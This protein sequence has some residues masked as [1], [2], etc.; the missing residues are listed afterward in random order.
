MFKVFNI[1]KNYRLKSYNI[2]LYALVIIAAIYGLIM[3][4][5]ADNSFTLKQAFG[6]VLA[7][8]WMTFLS[9][10][11]FNKLLKWHKLWYILAIILLIAVL[12]IGTKV[13]GATRWIVIGGFRIQPSEITKILLIL[14]FSKVII[15]QREKMDSWRFLGILTILLFIPLFL[16][17]N[18]PDLSQ[19]IL[20]FLILFVVIF[21]GGL[22]YKKLGKILAILVPILIVAFIYITNPNQKL[23]KPYQWVRVMA[24]INPEKYDDSIYQQQNSVVAIGSGGLTGK[25][26]NNEDP[27]SLLNNNYIPE[28]HTDFIFAAVG[29]QLGFIG[30]LSIVALLLFIIFEI[31]AVALKTKSEKGRLIAIGVATHIALQTFLNIGVVTRLLPN[32]GLALPFF[33]YGLSSLMTLATGIGIVLNISLQIEPYKHKDIYT[34][35]FVDIKFYRKKDR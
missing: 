15:K 25:G 2:R 19:T 18:E 35:D 21:V 24:F 27:T 5:S 14:F 17:V 12:V 32:T 34:K 11:D 30:V 4:N 29:E 22:S 33:S 31:I 26:L 13:L 16:I 7:I 6:I 8:S 20:T 3:I 23:L 9:F 1:F 10:V 28:A